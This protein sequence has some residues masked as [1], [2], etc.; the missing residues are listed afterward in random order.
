MY[1]NTFAMVCWWVACAAL[2]WPL[3]LAQDFLWT[4]ICEKKGQEQS[5]QYAQLASLAL[6][7]THPLLWDEFSLGS[8]WPQQD[9]TQSRPETNPQLAAKPS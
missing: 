6:L 4:T 9:E 8:L 7:C 3:G 2:P 5:F 1:T